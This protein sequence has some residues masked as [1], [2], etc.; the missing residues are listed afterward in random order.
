VGTVVLK[1]GRMPFRRHPATDPTRASH[2]AG[3]SIRVAEQ[4]Q[5]GQESALRLFLCPDLA[6]S[7]RFAARPRLLRACEKNHFL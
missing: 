2:C 5:G 6:A 1:N 3:G 7:L 4:P